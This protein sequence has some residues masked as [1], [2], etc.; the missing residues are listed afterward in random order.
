L[1]SRSLG[2]FP[3]MQSALD[4]PMWHSLRTRHAHLALG[5]KAARRYPPDITPFAAVENETSEAASDLLD[6]VSPGERVGVLNVQPSSLDGWE[7]LKEIDIYQYI[8]EGPI[9]E[10]RPAE[11][12]EVLSS[13][14]VPAMLELTALVYPAYFRKGTAELGDY[15][16]ILEDG[17]L[18]AMAGIRM[19]MDGY[20][21]IS[22]VCTHPDHRGKGYAKRLTS[23]LLHHICQQGDVPFLHTE[24][25]NVPAQA[26]YEKLGFSRRAVLPFR[27]M[28]RLG[29]DKEMREQGNSGRLP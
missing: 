21:E 14:H 19:S 3:L 10:L 11:E 20:Q 13:E 5:E 12:T 15:Y 9:D 24:S 4:N 2:K 25:D 8:W 7:V 18:C 1:G 23:H 29:G 17:H 26:I 22:A 28:E 27:V 16:G 6:L